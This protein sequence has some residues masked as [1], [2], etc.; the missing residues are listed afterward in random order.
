MK[1]ESKSWWHV[2][3]SWQ[4]M[5][6]CMFFSNIP[7][8]YAQSPDKITVAGCVKDAAGDFLIGAT[9][10]VKGISGGTITDIDGNYILKDVPR[11]ATLVFSYVGMQNKEVPVN[12]KSTINVTLLDDAL[13]LEQVVVI[14]YGSVK[15][16]DVTG[17]VT[18]VKTEA[19]KEIP[20]NSVEGLLQG[21]A[22]GLQVINSSQDPG[23]GATVR[24]R[25]GSSLR[26]SNA[27]L[28][29]VDGFPLGD[30]GDLKQIN[31]SD[32]VNME[33]LKDAS[34]SAIYGSR[35]ANGVIMITTKRAKT[36][37]T[38]IT[39]RQ[40]ITLSQ[41]DTKLDLW[42]DPV[43]MASLNNESRING[44]LDPL[45]VGKVSSTGVYYPSVEELQTTW[46][47]NTRWDDLVFRDTPVSNNTTATISSSND[48]TVFNLSANFYT[49]N[50]MYIKDDYTKGGYNLS[51]D[52]NIYDNF[53]VRFSNILSRGVRNANGGLSY[54]RNPIYPVYDENGDY[55]LTNASDFSHP[56]AITDL[57]KNETKS[58]DVI[59]SVA[60]EWQLFPFLKLTSQL[61][62][63]FGKSVSDR[64][65]PKKYTEAGEFSN[66]QAEIENWEGHN[67]VSE[68][69]ANFQKKF[70]KHDI[71]A[72][73]GYSYEYYM[74]R[75]SGLT[76]KDFVN[77]ALGNENMGAGNPEKNE[78]W[79][80]YS[81]NKLVSGMF[82][83]NYVYDNK[84]LLT[85]TARADGSSKFGK[86]NKWAMFPSGA[87]SWKAH[88]ESF[89]KNLNVF[90]ELKFRFSYGISGNQGI[91][92]YQTLSRYGTDKYYNDGSWATT[93][94]PGYVSGWTGPGW[95]YRV[96]SGIPNPDLKWETTAQADFG[97][98]MAFLNRRL[99]VSFDYYDKQTSD[100]LR[101]R[102]LALSS[103]YDK[104]W[105]NDGKIQNRGF[106]VT[107]DADILQTKDWQLSGTLIY[108]RNRNKVKDLGNTLESGLVT[109]PMTG[110]L[111]EYSGNSLEQYRDYT[112]ILAIGQP[113]NVFYGYKVDGIVQ[114]LNEGIDAGLSGDYANPGEFKYMNLNGDSEISEADK[115]IIG[116]P[117]PDFTASLALNLSW[118][119]FDVSVFFN[120]VFGQDVL[121]TKAFGEPS[122]SPLRWTPDNPTNKYPSLRD[123]R[124][125][126]ISDWWIEDGSFLRV[127]NLNIGYTFD[128]PKKSFLSKAR[129]YMNASNLYT[130]TKFKGYDPEVGLDGVYSG[131]YPRLRKWTFGL[132]LTF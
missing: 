104:M 120:G 24:I 32:I 72:M 12:G 7:V 107:V 64:Y 94:G 63:K 125:V 86:N 112:N 127:Q 128:L 92:P 102:N 31:P 56:M 75:S 53:K 100:L 67:L 77:E 109:D 76:G 91:S 48:R 3:L 30:A 68:T 2:F 28:V 21:R 51:V 60:L 22:A 36:G 16:S 116:D 20:A 54:W 18:S 131:G 74:S 70:D 35:G 124:Q 122:N 114:T 11:T 6:L 26:G 106:E 98:D 49:D 81:D 126:K 61:N 130:F 37:T 59:S 71:G 46:T 29:V 89:I 27:P 103:G 47:T 121:N 1:N 45:Y 9:V 132:D 117:N 84:Y 10:Q 39:V 40:Q 79:N 19:L 105:V 99:R 58:L 62:Y 101:E 55:Y 25:G 8:S 82:R 113:V 108:S 34:A 115:T 57:Q 83:L 95:I 4:I 93:I 73:V 17:S 52:H 69:F 123:G 44:G 23:A 43:L 97:I 38:N 50:G 90:D 129:I 66:G 42:R 110:M 78:I 33:I 13:Q 85:L 118:K 41:F 80:G 15:K 88:E 87:V 65:Y 119:K 96:W 14:G 111:F 5:A